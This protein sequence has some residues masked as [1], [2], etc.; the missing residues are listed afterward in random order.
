MDELRDDVDLKVDEMLK[1]I[2][3]KLLISYPDKALKLIAL[4]FIKNNFKLF[5]DAQRE[6]EKLAKSL[7]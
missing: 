7:Q 2:D 4:T 6:G 5:K 3:V 1:K